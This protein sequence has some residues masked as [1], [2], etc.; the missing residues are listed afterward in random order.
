MTL[1]PN[2]KKRNVEM[3]NSIIC[4]TEYKSYEN[5]CRDI[6]KGWEKNCPKC[7]REQVYSDKYGLWRAIHK[8]T[9]CNQCR[10]N[11]AK[12]APPIKGW[13]KLCS[14]C[15]GEIKYGNRKMYRR[16][17]LYGY[18]CVSCSEK[19][20]LLNNTQFIKF[21]NKVHNL[22]YDYSQTQY[23]NS[24]TKITIICKRHGAF[25]QT[26]NDHLSGYGCPHCGK[27]ISKD[28]IKFL[29]FLNIKQENRQV[30]I[31]SYKVDGIDK[32]TNT[33]YEFLG[34]YWHG[35]LA[36]F[37]PNDIHPRLHE[38]YKTLHSKTMS[39]LISL[40]NKGYSVRYIWENDWKNFKRGLTMQPNI[41]T[42]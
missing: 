31:G 38:S 25:C 23:I 41:Q 5:E 30:K 8:N 6:G 37:D 33:I 10:H 13:I 26:P 2:E 16:S 28:E 7:G 34:D 9:W 17:I 29:D 15:N 40:K 11:E 24:R 19:A 14:K 20:R 42:I 27:T 39:K 18:Q 4:D 12:I 36:K 32:D 21:A 22:K 35:N 1:I 3:T